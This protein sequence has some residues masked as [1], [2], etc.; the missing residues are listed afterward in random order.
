MLQIQTKG[1]PKHEDLQ[2]HTHM[3]RPQ[4]NRDSR[5][6]NPRTRRKGAGSNTFAGSDFQKPRKE[7]SKEVKL[8]FVC[9]P[10]RGN[11]ERNSLKARRFC[12][13]VHTQ[14]AVPFAPHLLFPQF[15]DD[16]IPDERRAG[17]NL[18]LSMLRRAAELW[19]F[20]N[21]IT[22]GMKEEIKAA[23]ALDIPVRYFTD[24]CVE[25]EAI[26]NEQD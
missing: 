13:F 24:T 12:R 10:F 6:R 1:D 7:G 9:S 14:G 8:I 22:D 23:L 2:Y 18:G 17:I 16:E 21:I 19:V 26:C 11:E 3:H 5:T 20:G 25:R 4:R 15:L